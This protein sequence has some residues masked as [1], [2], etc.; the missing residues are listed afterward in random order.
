MACLVS[1]VCCQNLV[2]E[3]DSEFEFVLLLRSAWLCGSQKMVMKD[4]CPER[5]QDSLG[6]PP[7]EQGENHEFSNLLLPDY[8]TRPFNPSAPS[9]AC[10]SSRSIPHCPRPLGLTVPD[11]CIHVNMHTCLTCWLQTLPHS[12]PETANTSTSSNATSMKSPLIHPH[13]LLP[14]THSLLC[15]FLLLSRL[16]FPAAWDSPK[17]AV[18]E[19]L[20]SVGLD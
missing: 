19:S 14:F 13:A 15:Y 8:I 1:E 5:S 17:W 16:C 3:T 7:E 18:Y 10:D 9:V 11:R 6:E 2:E 4:I 12:P 20:R